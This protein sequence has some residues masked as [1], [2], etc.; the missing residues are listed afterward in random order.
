MF[1]NGKA[2]YHPLYIDN[3]VDSFWLAFGS[4][5]T[6]AEPYLIGDNEY[7]PIKELVKMIG[8]SMGIQVKIIHF[9]FWPLFLLAFLIEMICV[10]LKIPPP[11]FR[12]RVEWFK[13]N[14]GFSISKAKKELGY[15]PR[16]G[17]REGLK[18]TAEWYLSN[19]YLK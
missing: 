2:F 1:G 3:L 13:Q 4:D 12:R 7:Y 19:G 14:R 10:P 9:P 8:E 11:L 17:I 18:K 6:Q 5:K 16:I 15:D